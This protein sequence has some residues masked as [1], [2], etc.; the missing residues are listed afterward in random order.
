MH[1]TALH[2]AAM[3]GHTPAALRLV[4]GGAD[5]L[6]QTF[7]G[8]TPMDWAARNGHVPCLIALHEAAKR[9]EG[10]RSPPGCTV[11][12]APDGEIA[13]KATRAAVA[14]EAVKGTHPQ[15]RGHHPAQ[16]PTVLGEG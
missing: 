6:A 15:P 12:Y 16:S 11:Y 8:Y 14:A 4:A 13:L 10:P 3:R 7:D 2:H 5:V 9:Q 1:F